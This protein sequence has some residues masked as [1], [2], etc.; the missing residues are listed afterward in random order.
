MVKVRFRDLKNG[1]TVREA[2]E[3]VTVTKRRFAEIN[4]KIPGCL[5]AADEKPE[6]A[7]DGG[8]EENDR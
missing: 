6:E 7:A 1:G 3:T 2:G 4:E 5:E 8:S